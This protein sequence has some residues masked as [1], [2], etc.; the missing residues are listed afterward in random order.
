MATSHLFLSDSK[1]KIITSYN[2]SG[3]RFILLDL[4]NTLTEE[5]AFDIDTLVSYTLK[6]SQH[7]EN[8]VC[9]ISSKSKNDIEKYFSDGD[10]IILIAEQ[11]C[12]Y[13][14]PQSQSWLQMAHLDFGWKKDINVLFQNMLVKYPDSFIEEKINSISWNYGTTTDIAGNDLETLENRCAAINT[15]NNFKVNAGYSSFEVKSSG[16]DK[17]VAASKILSSH[18]FDFIMA[19]GDNASDEELF[20]IFREKGYITISLANASST[21]K[22]TLRELNELM[23]FLQKITDSES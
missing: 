8:T 7:A 9:I 1:Q 5:N 14:L 21:A 18:S 17:G 19:I 6:L 12:T 20:R 10:N 22:Y 3:K 11:G 4:D 16:I 15:N 23:L 2:R 13:R